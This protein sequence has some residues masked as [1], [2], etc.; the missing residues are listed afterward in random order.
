MNKERF[1]TFLSLQDQDL[2]LD[3]LELKPGWL[4]T[5]QH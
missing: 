4:P 1:L 2:N 5:Q 3:L